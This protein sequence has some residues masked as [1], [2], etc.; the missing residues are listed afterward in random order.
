MP[1]RVAPDGA[2]MPG[3]A[4]LWCNSWGCSGICRDFGDDDD[5][6]FAPPSLE[7]DR[8]TQRA[9]DCARW[10]AAGA[11]RAAAARERVSAYDGWAQTRFFDALR[12]VEADAGHVMTEAD[13]S[14]RFSEE[15][16]AHTGDSLYEEDARAARALWAATH[17][18]ARGDAPSAL[19]AIHRRY[20]HR[21][22]V[23]RWG[24]E[25]GARRADRARER[26]GAGAD[27]FRRLRAI[28]AED[29]HVL[30][31]AELAVRGVAEAAA[32][33]SDE[34]T[35]REELEH[36]ANQQTQFE[37]G[38]RSQ[39]RDML[40]GWEPTRRATWNP[41]GCVATVME[42]HATDNGQKDFEYTLDFYDGVLCAAGEVDASPR[43]QAQID[44]RCRRMTAAPGA[45]AAAAAAAGI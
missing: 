22:E 14:A 6:T 10:G 5:R 27:F 21:L 42:Y 25:A 36:D 29:G 9:E 8:A 11:D 18:G 38:F 28:E 20:W 1:R 34:E 33:E 45:A 43:I 13:A 12:E 17:R 24:S 23:A 39:T 31:A 37:L 4:C 30:S 35:A 7:V 15:L 16:A 32:R 41:A 40:N 2:V 3:R 26:A 19:T 44:A